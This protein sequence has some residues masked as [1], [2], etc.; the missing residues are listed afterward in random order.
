MRLISPTS[1]CLSNLQ[2][3]SN[4]QLVRVSLAPPGSTK[5]LT[6]GKYLHRSIPYNVT[7]PHRQVCTL[8]RRFYRV[9]DIVG[10][11][12][13]DLYKLQINKAKTRTQFSEVRTIA[14]CF[15]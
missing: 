9:W 6:L 7:I 8:E 13:L 5:D 4:R 15:E 1:R 10:K 2:A 14:Q 3:I 11:L 12:I